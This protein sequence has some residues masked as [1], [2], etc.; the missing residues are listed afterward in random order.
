MCIDPLERRALMAV[1]LDAAGWTKITPAA[2][3]RVIYVSSTAGNDSNDGL[4]TATPVKS[5]SRGQALV[6]DGAADWLLLRR[7]DT[8]GGFG[9]WKKSGRSENEPLYIAAYGTGARPQINSGTSPGFFTWANGSRRINHVVISSLSFFPNSYN[10]YNAGG[11]LSAI[12]LT[13]PGDNITVEDCLLRGYKDNVVLDAVGA[14]L[15]RV[16][17]RRNVIAD[18]HAGSGVGNG[19]AQGIY[20]G[21][22]SRDVLI[23]Q[24]IFDHNGWRANTSSD[25]TF[26]S[27]NIYTQTGSTATVREN[28][29]SRAAFYGVKF[30]GSGTIENNLFLR[31]AESVYL[32]APATVRNNVITEAVDMPS[33]TWGVGINT[34]KSPSA[35]IRG[36]IVTRSLSTAG[37]GIQLFNNGTPFS[38]AVEDNIVY[39]WRNGLVASTPGA[40]PGTVVIRRNRLQMTSTSNPAIN[41]NS[42][43][44]QS[45][46]AYQGNVYA[47]ATS[48]TPAR[49]AGAG[50]SLSQWK[51]KTAEWDARFETISFPDPTR[52]IGRY[53]ATLGTGGSFDAFIAAARGMSSGNWDAR[54]LPAAANAWFAAGFG[55]ST[56]QATLSVVGGRM[57]SNLSR[58]TVRIE[59]SGNVGASLDS[60]DLLVRDSGGSDV[61]VAAVTWDS[62]ARVADFALTAPLVSGRYFATLR[63]GSVVADNGAVLTADFQLPFSFLAGDADGNGTVNLADFAALAARFNQPGT[64]A[65]GDFDYSG[66]I[67]IADLALLAVNFNN[68]LS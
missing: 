10:H 5:L 15:T 31:N 25:R 1:S 60:S 12:R 40:G 51:S 47:A 18:A 21:P 56:P 35:F 64:F 28:V 44:A 43:A 61:A 54:Y 26:F 59:F 41:Q 37:V 57:L 2:D 53:A 23:E 68:T 6:R 32:E 42:S 4:S 9:E 38:G 48:S 11:D 67:D 65:Q 46:F 49:I 13:C 33:Q 30:N 22:T 8:F 14:Q 34:Q 66:T 7:G 45:T 17:L 55:I 39:A 58:P 3:T 20:V 16:T 52:D 36:N 50:Q 27:H 29:I 19:H 24:N 62:A 63:A